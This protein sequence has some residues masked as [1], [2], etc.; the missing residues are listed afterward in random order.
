MSPTVPV[1][2]IQ[3][4]VQFAILT[5][6]LV[7]LGMPGRSL[8]GIDSPGWMSFDFLA[9]E[10]MI[11]DK[12]EDL[13]DQT[14]FFETRVDAY[15]NTN[16][17]QFGDTGLLIWA[18]LELS[19]PTGARHAGLLIDLDLSQ[20]STTNSRYLLR[21]NAVR[22]EY[23]EKQ[24]DQV[25]FW[26]TPVAG[27]IWVSDFFDQ[28][29]D[30]GGIEGSFDFIFSDPNDEYPGCRVFLR[31]YFTTV[32]SPTI[33]RDGIDYVEPEEDDYYY[34][35]EE[36][37]G[38]CS[39]EEA[40]VAAGCTEIFLEGCGAAMSGIDCE[41]DS[42]DSSGGCEGDTYEAS[43]SGR[44]RG[45][46]LRTLTRVIPQIGVLVFIRWFRRRKLRR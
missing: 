2:P 35:E 29:G 27:E 8:A 40:E 33:L 15:F 43:L 17:S 26:G 42:S 32:P 45:H 14:E 46:P 21:S 23:F 13:D 44:R 12:I 41:G 11:Y 16:A 6:C 1:R 39:G 38:G 24:D 31:G 18:G 9:E 7:C 25:L 28:A 3:L 30:Q 10:N 36:Y 34:E 22:A 5:V 20:V 37:G 4:K 19:S